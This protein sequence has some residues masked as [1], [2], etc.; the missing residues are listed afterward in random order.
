MRIM[1]TYVFANAEGKALD[2]NTRDR[3][4]TSGKERGLGD[5]GRCSVFSTC[6]SAVFQFLMGPCTFLVFKTF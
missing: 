3:G 4:F 5:M 2:R 6:T 1:C